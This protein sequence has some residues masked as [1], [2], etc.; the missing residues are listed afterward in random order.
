MTVSV[1]SRDTRTGSA[2]AFEPAGD[3]PA[4]KEAAE[5]EE[6]VGDE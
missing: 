3:F 4:C 1:M 6:L 5:T 2:A